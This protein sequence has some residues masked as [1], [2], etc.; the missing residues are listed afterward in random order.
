[1]ECDGRGRPHLIFS[2]LSGG[3]VARSDRQGA[4]V[5]VG[6]STVVTDDRRIALPQLLAVLWFFS[7]FKVRVIPDFF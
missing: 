1:M 5:L 4:T 6:F 7:R 3:G 2:P